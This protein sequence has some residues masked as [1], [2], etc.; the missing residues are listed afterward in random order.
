[1]TI[2]PDMHVCFDHYASVYNIMIAL[3]NARGILDVVL[4]HQLSNKIVTR[5]HIEIRKRLFAL[6]ESRS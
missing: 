6:K 2:I 5:F 1:M 3:S 4:M